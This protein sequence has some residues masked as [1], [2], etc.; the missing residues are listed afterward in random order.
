M[1][2]IHDHYITN[3]FVF[4]IDGRIISVVLNAP[5]SVHDSTLA[6]WGNVYETLESVY[7]NLSS[8]LHLLFVPFEICF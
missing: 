5:G 7:N 3:L 4:S 2:R 8:S 1:V 6:D